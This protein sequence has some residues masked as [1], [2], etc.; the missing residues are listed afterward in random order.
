[1]SNVLG[2]LFIWRHPFKS[3]SRLEQAESNWFPFMDRAATHGNET[4][5]SVSSI[6]QAARCAFGST[7]SM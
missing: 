7:E 1:M 4:Q 2:I 6:A 3:N 5:A